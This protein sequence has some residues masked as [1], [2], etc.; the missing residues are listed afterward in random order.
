MKK[1]LIQH[2]T[3]AQQEI[4]DL[5]KPFNQKYA[6]ALGYEYH[7]DSTMRCPERPYYWEKMAYI[8]E[9]LS[10]VEDGSL[11]VWED[12]DSLNVRNISFEEALPTGAVLGMTQNRGGLNLN[13]LINWYNSGVIVMIN[14]PSVREFFNQV[15]NTNVG[16]DEDSIMEVLKAN[17]MKIGDVPV[18]SIHPKWNCWKNNAKFAPEPVVQ[19]FHGIKLEEKLAEMRKIVG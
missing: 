10:T 1:Y 15:W 18:A 13:K 6:D 7:T 11:V 2:G 4:I 3:A 5:V 8:K 19:T 14:L 16:F 17:D 9:F 12:A